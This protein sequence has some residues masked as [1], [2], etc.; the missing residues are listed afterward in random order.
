MKIQAQ[1]ITRWNIYDMVYWKKDLW[2]MFMQVRLFRN[3]A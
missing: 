2:E 3:L 1:N